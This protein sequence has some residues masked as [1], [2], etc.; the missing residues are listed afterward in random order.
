[1]A[2]LSTAAKNKELMLAEE[3]ED[4]IDFDEDDQIDQSKVKGGECFTHL[5]FCCLLAYEY[6]HQLMNHIDNQSVLQ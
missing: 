4:L 5:L 3:V 1:M 2:A 6:I